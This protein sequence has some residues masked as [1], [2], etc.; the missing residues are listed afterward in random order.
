MLPKFRSK[1]F[2]APM[3]AVTN[4]AFRQ[5]CCRYGA[6][7]TCTEFVSARAILQDNVKSFR[8]LDV[9]HDVRPVSIQLFGD[10][11]KHLGEAAAIVS[12][13]CDIVDLNLGCPARKVHDAG[14]GSA[15]L[16]KP[17][18]VKEIVSSMV[19]ASSVPVSVKIR[20]GLDSKR[21]TAAKIASIC[22]DAGAS[23]VTVHGRTRDQGYAGEA[24][25]DHIKEVV[26]AVSVPVVGNGDIRC[27]ADA[28]RMFAT[29][30]AYVAIGRGAI[31]DPHVFTRVNHYLQTGEEMACLPVAEKVELFREYIALCGQYELDSLHHMKVA[32]QPFLAGFAG[33]RQLR[34]ELQGLQS[35]EDIMALLTQ[36]P[37]L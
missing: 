25:L 11:A 2:L 35:K 24:N 3:A 23:L 9:S 26:D 30:C 6:G 18:Q 16:D 22:V 34:A 32:C 13:Q 12:K 19:S 7:L 4:T 20:T 17:K 33:A 31:G 8:M 10:T 15:L 29:G 5:L 1:A 36:R 21:I 37:L 27:G 28:E 14:C